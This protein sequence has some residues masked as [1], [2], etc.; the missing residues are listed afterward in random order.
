MAGLELK[1]W[2]EPANTIKG[3]L[4]TELIK[5]MSRT[6]KERPGNKAVGTV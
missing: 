3:S 6:A 2:A 5:S 1:G 4:I